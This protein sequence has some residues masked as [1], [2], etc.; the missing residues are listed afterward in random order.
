MK[1]LLQAHMKLTE[2]INI[3]IQSTLNKLTEFRFDIK[4]KEDIDFFRNK[5]YQ[6]N[7]HTKLK[8]NKADYCFTGLDFVCNLFIIESEKY[9]ICV[10]FTAY[11]DGMKI[12]YINNLQIETV[13]SERNLLR[14]EPNGSTTI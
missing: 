8:I 10:S 6:L 3:D 12:Y 5:Y 4:N 11:S 14:N 1:N 9:D 2:T 7:D 13:Y